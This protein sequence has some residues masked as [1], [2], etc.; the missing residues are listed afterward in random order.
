MNTL[1]LIEVSVEYINKYLDEYFIISSS[2]LK[3]TSPPIYGMLNSTFIT[4]FLKVFLLPAKRSSHSQPKQTL[5][6]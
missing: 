1:I 6:V 2:L 5:K 4:L 3:G